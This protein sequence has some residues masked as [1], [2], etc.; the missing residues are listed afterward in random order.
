M[1]KEGEQVKELGTTIQEKTEEGDSVSV[2]DNTK[3]AGNADETQ[4]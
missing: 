2:E 1:E 3:A 4:N